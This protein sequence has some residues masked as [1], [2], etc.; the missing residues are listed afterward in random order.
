MLRW[1]DCLDDDQPPAATRARKRQNAGRLIVIAEAI[2]IGVT[3]V[4]RR[5]PEQM[6][7]PCDIG[8]AVAVSVEAI[9]ANAVLAFGEHV[10]QEP[11]DELWGRERHGGVTSCA[12]KAV[13][14]DAEGDTA[15][16]E[17]DQAAVGNGDPMGVARQVCQHG[18]WP[19]ERFLCIDDPVDPAQRFEKGIE[20][21]A[22]SEACKM[23]EEV[24][25]PGFVQ[26]GQTFQN[27]TPV[28]TRQHPNG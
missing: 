13:I 18:L 12:F 23:A 15:L 28:Q 7:D 27:Q 14:F 26:L 11:T 17:T 21:V 24:Q 4:T 2:I 25:L 19:R 5:S 6:P 3:L 1:C 16:I 22:I 20:S 10:D 8:R 9:V